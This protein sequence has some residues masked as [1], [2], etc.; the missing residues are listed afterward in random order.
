MSFSPEHNN[1]NYSDWYQPVNPRENIYTAG[2]GWAPKPPH[3][4]ELQLISH[5]AT[6]VILCLVGYMF[7]DS[8]IYNTLTDFFGIILPINIYI[9]ISGALNEFTIM[10]SVVISMLLPFSLYA[11]YVKIPLRCA[12]PMR[13]VPAGLIIS[14]TFVCLAVTVLSG[15]CADVVYYLFE[16]ANLH[17]YD[18]LND[19]PTDMLESVLYCVN[20]IFIAPIIEEIAFRGFLMQSLR[21]FGD[22]FALIVSAVL[23]GLLHGSPVSISYAIPMGLVMGYFVLFTG[24]LHTAMIV[25]F[26]N[27]LLAVL[28][29]VAMQYFPDGGYV[30]SLGFDTASLIFGILAVIWLMRHYENIF[31]L[32]CSRTVNRSTAK[33][34]RF[35]VSPPFILFLLVIIYQA[36][37]LIV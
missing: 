3:V 23:F 26:I 18:S 17:F 9:G 32:K 12:L 27:N 21:R 19:M 34:K 13:S 1:N 8:Y 31:S 15:Y 29:T 4:I 5:S 2:Y 22:S 35:F 33:I 28:L 16:T 37:R 14:A 7:L 20:I 11:M 10:V 25:H 30:F 36:W 6:A 24:S